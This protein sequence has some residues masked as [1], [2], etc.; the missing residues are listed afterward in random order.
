MCLCAI[1]VLFWV[2][3]ACYFELSDRVVLGLLFVCLFFV[4]S[5]CGGFLRGFCSLFVCICELFFP[6][7]INNPP[8]P[9]SP[10]TLPK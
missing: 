9:P 3:G 2:Y 1:F 5:V 7:F 10:S 6:L 4:F 8:M